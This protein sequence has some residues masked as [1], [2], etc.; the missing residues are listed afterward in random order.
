VV[1]S[2]QVHIT[3]KEYMKKIRSKSKL[4]KMGALLAVPALALAGMAVFRPNPSTDATAPIITNGDLM[5]TVSIENCPTELTWVRDARDNNTYWI[6][7]IVGGGAG[8]SDLCWMF[9][10]LAYSGG[11]NNAYGDAKNITEFIYSGTGAGMGNDSALWTAPPSSSALLSLYPN[12]PSVAY[13]SDVDAQYGFLYN[14]C[15][16]MGGQAPACNMTETDQ[17]NINTSVSV[18]PAGWR[19]PVGGMDDPA[20]NDFTALNDAINGSSLTTTAGL[21]EDW[22]G[23]YAGILHSGAD[24]IDTGFAYQTSR[25]YYFSSTL[26]SDTHARTL[27]FRSGFVNPANDNNKGR[28]MSVRCVNDSPYI[29]EIVAPTLSPTEGSVAGGTLVTITG[30]GV[31]NATAILFG[32]EQATDLTVIDEDTITI[33]TP[34]HAFGVVDVTISFGQGA[35]VLEGAFTFVP[36]I[37]NTAGSLEKMAIILVGS[38]A[39]AVVLFVLARKKQLLSRKTA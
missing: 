27:Q 39:L 34:A 3:G 6:K 17:A 18:C 19:L 36:G 13:G 30:T 20:V 23:V 16:A 21:R 32:N 4:I 2:V 28:G 1:S 22:L 15:S 12:P 10:N 11:G 5:Q 8:G 37:P 24:G 38:S 26:F 7:K 25:A 14:W 31:G 29:P 33:K 9:T 35:I